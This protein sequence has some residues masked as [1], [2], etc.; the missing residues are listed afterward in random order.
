MAISTGLV[1]VKSFSLQ[2]FSHSH[3]ITYNSGGWESEI[4]PVGCCATYPPRVW[5]SEEDDVTSH[6][7]THSPYSKQDSPPRVPSASQV[8]RWQCFKK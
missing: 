4:D 1:P 3:K 2:S 5:L 7:E 6:I 8:P